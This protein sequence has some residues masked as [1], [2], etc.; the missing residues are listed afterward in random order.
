M[1]FNEFYQNLF[2]D[3][4]NLGSIISAMIIWSIIYLPITWYLEKVYP[5]DYGIPLPFY[6]PITVRHILS[7]LSTQLIYSFIINY[8]QANYW[9]PQTLKIQPKDMQ[10]NKASDL[11]FEREPFNYRKTVNLFNLSKVSS[12]FEDVFYQN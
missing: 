3:P 5:G 7:I 9:F 4:L 12:F 2:D 6:F 1:G 11:N 8:K 10:N